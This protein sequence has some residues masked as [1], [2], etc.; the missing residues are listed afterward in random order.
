[1]HPFSTRYTESV[2]PAL[3]AGRQYPSTYLIPKVSKVVVNVGIGDLK[4]NNKAIDDA[5]ELLG[6]IVGQR[7][8]RTKA[9]KAIASFKI[10]QNMVVGLKVTLRGKRMED[11]LYKF[12]EVALPRTRDFRGLKASGITSDGNLNVGIR[13]A[14][15]FP[16]AG[17]DI[18][19]LGLQVTIVSN[20]A[21]LEDATR[22]YKGLGFYFKTS[23]DD[24]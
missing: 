15:I 7:P 17:E 21:S 6:R 1:M 2:V 4:E 23:E 14:M 24:R 13:D 9:R 5:A 19:Q 11:F 18:S 20:A 22:L 12:I 10:R 8:V 3:T 16:E